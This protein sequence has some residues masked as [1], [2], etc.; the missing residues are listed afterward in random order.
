[1]EGK[2]WG[3][4]EAIGIAFEVFFMGFVISM[5]VALIIK[6]TYMVINVSS[7]PKGL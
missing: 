2:V 6:L 5:F 3:M 1:M 4:L 7:K